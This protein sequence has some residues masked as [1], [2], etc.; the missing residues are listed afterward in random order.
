VD[1]RIQL[2]REV[3]CSGHGHMWAPTQHRLDGSAG[4]QQLLCLRA[5]AFGLAAGMPCASFPYFGCSTGS[6][7]WTRFGQ[8]VN[9]STFDLCSI[10]KF[11]C[12]RPCPPPPI[13]CCRWWPP[14][15]RP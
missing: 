11:P 14:C 8:Q 9:G 3:A 7:L 2:K 13:C 4:G 5:L 6:L 12:P 10:N 15:C 1:K